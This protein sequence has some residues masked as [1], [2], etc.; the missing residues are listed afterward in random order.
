MLVLRVLREA[1]M[2]NLVVESLCLGAESNPGGAL[3][4]VEPVTPGTRLELPSVTI[5]TVGAKVQQ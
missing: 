5:V 2:R 1:L 3:P 4:P